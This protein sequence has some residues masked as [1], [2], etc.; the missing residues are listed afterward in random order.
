MIPH[1]CVD[2]N[3][4]N[5]CATHHNG[6]H[7]PTLRI[8]LGSSIPISHVQIYNSIGGTNCCCNN[9]A[10]TWSSTIPGSGIGSTNS[11]IG[12]STDN[13][14]LDENDNAIDINIYYNYCYIDYWTNCYDSHVH[15]N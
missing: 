4:N 8:D 3:L 9:N 13:N 2:G 14:E 5:Y 12:D 10:G 11:N 7:N 1:R 6:A 15:I